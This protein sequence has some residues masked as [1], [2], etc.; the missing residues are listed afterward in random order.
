MLPLLVA[1]AATRAIPDAL[2]SS[3]ATQTAASASST[4]EWTPTLRVGPSVFGAFGPAGQC[5]ECFFPAG[6]MLAQGT[7]FDFVLQKG[8]SHVRW[9]N[10]LAL[11]L[12]WGTRT[13][14]RSGDCSDYS[15]APPGEYC[16]GGSYSYTDRYTGPLVAVFLGTG[17]RVDAAP[18]SDSAFLTELDGTIGASMAPHLGA[19]GIHLAVGARFARHWEVL[20]STETDVLAYAHGSVAVVMGYSP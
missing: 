17:F 12:G 2:S 19:L 1:L 6:E 3:P 16:Y 18:D 15:P 10:I 8:R 9:H 11:E 13:T 20:A 5:D 14:P 4:S 7:R